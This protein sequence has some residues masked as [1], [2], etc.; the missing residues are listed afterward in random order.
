MIRVFVLLALCAPVNRS[1]ASFIQV[2]VSAHGF[3]LIEDTMNVTRFV[4]AV[5]SC[6]TLTGCANYANEAAQLRE[7]CNAGND[8]ASCLDY[9]SL[10]QACLFPQ[11]PVQEYG[12]R[13]V[14]P[15]HPRK[16]E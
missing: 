6:I 12:C 14:G 4:V 11:G 5:L 7:T 8:K 2:G 1:L 16:P 13:G 10:V 15:T 3:T 9:Q